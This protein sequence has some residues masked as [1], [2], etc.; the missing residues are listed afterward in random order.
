[1]RMPPSNTKNHIPYESSLLLRT[2]HL[3]NSLITA[4]LWQYI[5]H[6][7]INGYKCKAPIV[8]DTSLPSEG[9]SEEAKESGKVAAMV[10]RFTFLALPNYVVHD[11]ISFHQQYKQGKKEQKKVVIW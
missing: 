2:K 7:A 11:S 9:E 10:L 3:Y 4:G 5:S 6:L 1:M 8:L